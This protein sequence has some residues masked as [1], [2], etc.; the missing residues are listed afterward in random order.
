ME[1]GQ[2]SEAPRGAVSR[3][4]F[5]ARFNRV[6]SGLDPD[7]VYGLLQKVMGRVEQ[8]EA[9]AQRASAPAVM[10]ATL[11]EAAEICGKA[12]ELAEHAYEEVVGA[13]QQE[14][15]RIRAEAHAQ[16]EQIVQAGRDQGER[17]R[18][19]ARREG[20]AIIDEARREAAELHQKAVEYVKLARTML[21]EARREAENTAAQPGGTSD[22]VPAAA[23]PPSE[24]VDPAHRNGTHAGETVAPSPAP[25]QEGEVATLASALERL[26]SQV[27]RAD[28]TP[29]APRD[30]RGERPGR[31]EL[32]GWLEG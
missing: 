29:P 16:A 7:Q 2:A 32:P 11:H 8:L 14:A 12:T 10:R 3:E 27:R 31:F 26:G 21:G 6:P 18:H 19:E 1:Q 28:S 4:A 15:E 22:P 20:Q 9:Q 5:L 13:A 25:Q 23:W 30:Q 17:L 24:S